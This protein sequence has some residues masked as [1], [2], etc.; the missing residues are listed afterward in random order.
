MSISIDIDTSFVIIQIVIVFMLILG[1]P[2][3][4]GRQ[5]RKNLIRHGY[6]TI[7][8]L[9][10]HTIIVIIVMVFLAMDGFMRITNLSTPSL[11]VVVSHMVVGQ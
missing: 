4:K 6:L 5:N 1:L 7:F 8:A 11:F 2:L 3:A 9:V 10:L